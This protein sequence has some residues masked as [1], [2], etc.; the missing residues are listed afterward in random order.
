[1]D[2]GVIEGWYN[3]KH[4]FFSC[5]VPERLELYLDMASDLWEMCFIFIVQQHQEIMKTNYLI[6]NDLI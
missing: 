4:V 5:V 6:Y 1:M 3:G 2:K